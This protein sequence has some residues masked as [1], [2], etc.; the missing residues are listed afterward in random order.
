MLG[1]LRAQHVRLFGLEHQT[2]LAEDVLARVEGVLGD[3][4]VLEQ[5][6]GDEDRFNVLVG[7]ELAIILVFCGVGADDERHL[8]HFF[9]VDVAH[10]GATSIVDFGEVLEKVAS[11]SA[12]ADHDVFHLFGSG[13]H[14][15]GGALNPGQRG[16]SAGCA[17]YFHYVTS[18][19]ISHVVACYK[20]IRFVKRLAILLGG[21]R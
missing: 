18:G 16:S 4:V 14:N 2:L 9:G 3:L 8:V 15:R 6:D 20:S 12:G 19:G 5:R 1:H 13:F 7:E 21:G 10:G 17:S 11:A